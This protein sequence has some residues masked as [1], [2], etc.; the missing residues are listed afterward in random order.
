MEL[1]ELLR[2]EAEDAG[3]AQAVAEAEGA[4]EV[5]E[6]EAGKVRRRA[7]AHKTEGAAGTVVRR[8]GRKRVVLGARAEKRTGHILYQR[9]RSR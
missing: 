9:S 1:A 6:A 4:A 2:A 8:R 7:E 5:A 3:A